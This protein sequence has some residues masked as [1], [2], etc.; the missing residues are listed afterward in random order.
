MPATPAHWSLRLERIVPACNCRRHWSVSREPTLFHP[1]GALVRRWGRIG[2][3]T[4]TAAAQPLDAEP[5]LELAR[6]LALAKLRRGY[7]VAACSWPGLLA[8]A[9]PQPAATAK[10]DLQLNLFLNGKPVDPEP[11]NP[12][13]AWLSI[14]V[15]PSVSTAVG[16]GQLPLLQ[17]AAGERPGG[18]TMP[19]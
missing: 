18:A 3:W 6:T 4:R 15:G 2:A 19:P 8:D 16:L 7:T 5:A 9:G 11:A 14:P 10:V 17:P 12:V 1:A 13:S